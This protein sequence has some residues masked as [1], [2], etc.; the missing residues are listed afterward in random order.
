MSSIIKE[1][2][3]KNVIKKLPHFVK[4]DT[5]YETIMGSFAYGVSTEMSD[6]DIYGF[7]IPDKEIVFP[8]LGGEIFGFGKQSKRFEQYQQ[9][10]IMYNNKEY[11]ISCYNIVKYFQ[12]CMEN[13]P[14]M[15]D[16][17]FTD[18]TC[19]IHQTPIARHVRANRTVFLH[20]G[21][22]H[23]FKGYAFSQMNKIQAKNPD[24]TSKRYA[25]IMEHGY[26][27][28]Y[29]YH[30]V[31]L[32]N[33][34]EQILTHHD[35]DLR[36]NNRHLISIRNGEWTADQIK[37]WFHAKEIGLEELYQKSTLPKYPDEAKIKTLLLECLEEHYGSISDSFVNEDRYK[38]L[39][40]EINKMTT[41]ALAKKEK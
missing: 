35:L 30:I 18:N 6:V 34:V 29:A 26:D 32:I 37:E 20:K 8:H 11:D 33:E 9:H 22:W 25:S 16:S 14:N 2:S 15:I 28:K 23:K 13:N 19:V 31:R 41:R 12:L 17:L 10:H 27:V 4:N 7:C 38:D 5:Q 24:P 36:E 40:I 1:L 21:C 39:I 3:E